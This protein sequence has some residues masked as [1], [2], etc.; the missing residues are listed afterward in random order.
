MMKTMTQ[1]EKELSKKYYGK[2]IDVKIND[3]IIRGEYH[4]TLSENQAVFR[5]WDSGKLK[6]KIIQIQQIQ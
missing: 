6:M 1:K 4:E 3:Q 2:N 5:Y